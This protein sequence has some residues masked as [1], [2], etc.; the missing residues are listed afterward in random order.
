MTLHAA[1]LDWPETKKLTA[2]FAKH[3]VS[4]RFVGG[5]VRDAL[6]EKIADDIDAA[7]PLAPEHVMDLLETEGVKAVPTGIDHGTVTA[8]IGKKSFEI[9]TLRKDTACDGRHAAVE[10]TEDW[11]EDAR[12]R[13]F[14]INAFYLSPEGHLFDYFHGRQDLEN[15]VVRFIG[16]ADDRVQEDFLRILRFFRFY[17]RYAK[18]APDAEAM[19]ACKKHAPQIAM[20]SGERIQQEMLKL[21]AASLVSPAL[22]AMA[23]IQLLGRVIPRAEVENV[24]RLEQLEQKTGIV[25][26]ANIRLASLLAH[27]SEKEIET[28]A[29]RL[30]LP[31]VLGKFLKSTLA[32]AEEIKPD[33]TLAAQKKNLR[34]AGQ[35][36][37]SAAVLVAAANASNPAAYLPLLDLPK[38]WTPPEFPVT[39][40][41][42]IAKGMVEGR[43]LGTRLR[44]LEEQWEASDYSLT[45]TELL[46]RI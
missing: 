17:A 8:V 3:K 21:L 29:T 12:R 33:I 13:D 7:T 44:E 11:E 25:P 35:K 43:E 23:E 18:G 38:Q 30:K 32:R 37:Y 26:Q 27:A 39:G 16:K 14:T 22:T 1:W 20:L 24:K 19:A 10:Y 28:L 45:K 4:L 31:A 36:Y 46:K 5:C 41:D 6:L 40:A 2:L 34:R 15:G 9:T 42:L